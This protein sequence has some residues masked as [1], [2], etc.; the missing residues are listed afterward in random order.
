MMRKANRMEEIDAAVNKFEPVTPDHEFYVN[1]EN[2]RGNFQE[3][4]VM[5]ILNAIPKNGKYHFDY[6]PNRY[7]KTLL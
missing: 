6:Q 7:N 5:R 4:R 3:R 1:F 2:L